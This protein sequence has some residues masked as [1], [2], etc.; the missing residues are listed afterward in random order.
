MAAQ[1]AQYL[2]SKALTAPSY[3]LHLM[4]IEGA[5]RFGRQAA[6]ALQRGDQM[7]AATPMLRVVDIVGEMLAAVRGSASN[8]NKRLTELYWFLFRLASEAK[9]HS[10]LEKLAAL[11]RLLE[12]ERQT[13]QMLC[14]KLGNDASSNGSPAG[15]SATSSPKTG[16]SLEA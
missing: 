14:D 6:E 9:I 8:V 11:M 16:F 1:N 4:L 10:D 3:R 13:W 7:A 15:N 2:E 12:Y 5:I